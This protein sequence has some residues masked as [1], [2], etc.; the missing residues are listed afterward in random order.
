MRLRLP[1]SQAREHLPFLLLAFPALAIAV[2]L[3]HDLT[4]PYDIDFQ[5]E[6]AQAQVLVDGAWSSEPFYLGERLWYPP[7]GPALVA[8]LARLTGLPVPLVSA[9]AGAY[10]NFLAPLFLY[11]LARRLFGRVAGLAAV[12]DYL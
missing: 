5:R 8:A 10:V 6:I 1:T 11:L 12:L 3:T 7:L 2:A 9:R 4:W